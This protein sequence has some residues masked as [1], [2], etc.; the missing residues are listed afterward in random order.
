MVMMDSIYPIWALM[1]DF[2]SGV[3][4][5]LSMTML[6]YIYM[7]LGSQHIRIVRILW[8]TQAICSM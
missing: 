4:K 5:H 3:K 2:L 1:M 6:F 7:E 8:S